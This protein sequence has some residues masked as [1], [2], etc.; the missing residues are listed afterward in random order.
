LPP[1][2]A[3]ADF[4]TAKKKGTG[5][6][7]FHPDMSRLTQQSAHDGTWVSVDA[8]LLPFI[9]ESLETAWERGYLKD[10]CDLTDYRL[11]GMN[12]GWEVAGP[13]DVAIQVKGFE[14]KA[15]FTDK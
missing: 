8:D 1:A 7:I 6:F 3:A 2:Y 4:S 15:V 14:L 5:K 12:M 13:L 11:G 9:K 10:S